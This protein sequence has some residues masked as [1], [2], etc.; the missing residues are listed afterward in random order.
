[1]IA[2][3]AVLGAFKRSQ[4]DKCYSCVFQRTPSVAGLLIEIKK[5]CVNS[6]VAMVTVF[7][8]KQQLLKEK[9]KGNTIL[10]IKYIDDITVIIEEENAKYIFN[11][12]PNNVYEHRQRQ[13]LIISSVIILML[14]IFCIIVGLIVKKCKIARKNNVVVTPQNSEIPCTIL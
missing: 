4:F 13:I 2:L 10:T 6:D 12:R 1:M 11:K 9:L 7:Y 5:Y 3:L 14:V 8:H